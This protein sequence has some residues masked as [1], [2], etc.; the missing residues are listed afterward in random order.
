M[1][2]YAGFY[3]ILVLLCA[4]LGYNYT[5]ILQTDEYLAQTAR[6]LRV[7]CNEPDER[8]KAAYETLAEEF[9]NREALITSFINHSA[10]NEARNNIIEIRYDIEYGDICKLKSD[11]DELISYLE[12][13]ADN[14]KLKINNIF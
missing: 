3:V 4:I 5:V 11:V 2:N 7:M 6:E 14:E 8:L 1:K 12:D 13:I 9:Y 10:Y